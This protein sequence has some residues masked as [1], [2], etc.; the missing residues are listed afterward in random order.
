IATSRR[1]LIET[2][3]GFQAW[4]YGKIKQVKGVD[5]TGKNTAS[6]AK[7]MTLTIKTDREYTLHGKGAEFTLLAKELVSKTRKKK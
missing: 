1:L 6:A 3:E 2:A 7:M 5:G 4:P